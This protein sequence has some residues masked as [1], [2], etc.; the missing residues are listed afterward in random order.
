MSVSKLLK[1]WSERLFISVKSR[2]VPGTLRYVLYRGMVLLGP[3]GQRERTFDKRF[4]VETSGTVGKYELGVDT[5]NVI[6]AVEYRP[7]PIEDFKRIIGGLAI[8]YKDWTFLDLGAGKGR[9]VLLAL[10]YNFKTVVGVEF[11]PDLAR[12]AQSNLSPFKNAHILCQDAAEYIFPQDPLVIFL[13][14]PFHGTVMEQV[15][16][17]LGD[18]LLSHPR[19]VY[20]AYWNPFCQALFNAAPFLIK[21]HGTTEYA[22]YRSAIGQEADSTVHSNQILAAPHTIRGRES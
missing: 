10:E 7:A 6:Y 2:G 3:K 16:A 17:H 4:G 11:S 5:P 12:I 21:L 20:I 13:N 18:S 15:L 9:A 1:F 19:D 14:N 22:L 8:N